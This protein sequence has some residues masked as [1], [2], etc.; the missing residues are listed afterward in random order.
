MAR[1]GPARQIEKE[2]MQTVTQ[3]PLQDV[4]PIALASARDALGRAIEFLECPELLTAGMFWYRVDDS[5]DV[6]LE[7]APE[8]APDSPERMIYLPANANPVIVAIAAAFQAR[9]VWCQ[10]HGDE[11]RHATESW[12]RAF[13]AD[14]I[15]EA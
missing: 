2:V 5:E 1:I 4:P 13:V 12:A 15:G 6:I 9:R 7:T 11:S 3:V 14:W 8:A 10:T